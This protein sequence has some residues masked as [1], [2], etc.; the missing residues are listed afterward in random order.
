[1][2]TNLPKKIEIGKINNFSF[3]NPDATNDEL[4]KQ[5]L[6]ICK[7]KPI[8]EFLRDKTSILIGDRGAGKT[9]L[10]ELIKDKILTFNENNSCSHIIIPIDQQ[11]DYKILKEKVISCIQGE[12]K[13]EQLRYRLI[14]EILFLFNIINAIKD[15]IE[16]PDNLKNMI[17]IFEKSFSL[18]QTQSKLLDIFLSSKRS[19]GIKIEPTVTGFARADFYFAMAPDE[20]SESKVPSDVLKVSEL[21]RV[22]N[23]VLID[24]NIKVYILVDKID[25]FVIRDEY[26]VQKLALQGLL[27]T[28]NSYCQF[29]HLRPKLFIR[30]DLYR[31]IDLREYGSD[32]I[33]ARTMYLKWE[34]EDIRDL[35]AKRIVHNY[36]Y[37]LGMEH[38]NVM[39]AKSSLYLDKNS[40]DLLE[41]DGDEKVNVVNRLSRY[42]KNKMEQS[43][44]RI[45]CIFGSKSTLK[46][47]A[48]R[49]NFND[50]VNV[51]I[52]KT[53]FGE[54]AEHYDVE[55]K[56]EHLDIEK[57]LETH[58]NLSNM[59]TT[60]RMMITFSENCL[61]ELRDYYEKNRDLDK[62]IS[63]PLMGPEL[64]LKAY[65]SYKTKLWET[66]AT[67]SNCW[68]EA[69]FN[70]KSKSKQEC[71]TAR[72]LTA[73]TATSN[74]NR[75]NEFISVVS[76]LG[77]IKC[78]NKSVPFKERTYC[79]P[80]LFRNPKQ[81]KKKT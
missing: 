65:T 49:V 39:V 59:S 63:F 79:L 74:E 53:F 20:K 37:V 32:K 26:E 24:N 13:D 30:N 38:I 70:L 45:K 52:I 77:V 29:S 60:P 27:S 18:D 8:R 44:H 10:F 11:L 14:W 75:I 56:N 55:N 76:H 12:I 31:H 25:A 21:K 5:T 48:R 6:C 40:N 19:I 62:N 68:K 16:I 36:L 35:L 50:Q 72:D 9:A 51:D 57:Y 28:E 7:I 81:K 80:I 1:M 46:L 33:A 64:I 67:E 43:N 58:F 47:L 22:I 41:E 66:I 71:I 69:V 42:I 78:E 23:K 15:K 73:I 61:S 3:G 4:I 34:A 54:K 17:E 2:I